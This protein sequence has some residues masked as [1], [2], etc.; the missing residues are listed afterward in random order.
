MLQRIYIIEIGMYKHTCSK[1]KMTLT[2]SIMHFHLTAEFI[3]EDCRYR[4]LERPE[5]GVMQRE[6]WKVSLFHFARLCYVKSP[7]VS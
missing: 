3:C 5:L 1:M 7:Q 2:H 4:H 6:L